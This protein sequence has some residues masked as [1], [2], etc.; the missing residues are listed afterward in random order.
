MNSCIKSLVNHPGL[1]KTS[2][3][4]LFLAQQKRLIS[5][6]MKTLTSSINS[7]TQRTHNCGQLTKKDVGKRVDLYGWVQHTR[8][9]NK[10]IS[11]RD[12]YGV[13]QCIVEKDLLTPTFR[14][15]N[16]YNE[17]VL[18]VSGV[19][20]ERP[21]EN[22]DSPKDTDEIEILVDK[23]KV[24]NL[25]NKD[26]PILTRDPRV[27]NSPSHQNK[28]KYRYIHLRGA[29]MQHALRFRSQICRILRNKLY[30]HNFVECETP[31]LFNRTPG[32]ANEFIVPTREANKFYSLVQSPQQLKQ[33]L[34]IGGLDRYFQ[35]CRCYRDETS[36]SDRQP[37]FTQLDI[38]LSFTT[39]DLMMNLVDELVHHLL[40]SISSCDEM[41]QSLT[42]SFDSNNHIRRM[43]YQE[44]FEKYG[45]DK[46]D[47]RFDWPIQ[48][49][50]DDSLYIDIPFKIDR[51]ELFTILEATKDRLNMLTGAP[52]ITFETNNNHVEDAYT[53]IHTSQRSDSARKL[54]GALRTAIAKELNEKGERV[55]KGE[56]VFLWV[57]E[58][59]L[60]TF[61]DQGKLEPNHHPFTAPTEDSL[62]LLDINP[63]LVK[64][65]HYD[66]VL[67]GQEVAGGSIRIHDT[68][69][70]KKI[71]TNI[72]K[73]DESNF[74]YF[75]EAL[76]S[77]CPPHGGIAFGL[78]RLVA[79]L[80]NKNSI[81]DVI[82]FPKSIS[83]R[84]P[85]TGCPDAISAEVKSLYHL[86]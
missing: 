33:L 79:I 47:L 21:V 80:L 52:L 51:E 44:A 71:F 10:I 59:P 9:N 60:F 46:P 48:E 39:Q 38:E 35:I 76:S 50:D 8:F 42:S 55:Y 74:G 41:L 16:I 25:A 30:E 23:V 62:H 58:F 36:R 32:G 29:E 56:L 45:T 1:N 27:S 67:N 69:L 63:L 28:F 78:D 11:L 22:T 72:L 15:S 53:R 37:E 85:M 77:G 13:V 54:L 31:T 4:S 34:M 84:D 65:Q 20:K 26:L 24:L 75:I 5:L 68:V 86:S 12:S 70:Q 3:S 81:R 19:V 66:L 64:G 73:V 17:S 49:H 43:A 14:K 82:A 2:L 7:F 40:V 61:D 18:E 57:T 83:G 6:S